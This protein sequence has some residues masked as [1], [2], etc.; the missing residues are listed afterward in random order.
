MARLWRVC[1]RLRKKKTP[2]A[3]RIPP[4]RSLAG[5]ARQCGFPFVVWVRVAWHFVGFAIGNVIAFGTGEKMVDAVLVVIVNALH[6]G[7]LYVVFLGKALEVAWKRRPNLRRPL[8]VHLWERR[9]TP[10]R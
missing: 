8:G 1:S 10:R 3:V 6:V 4:R 9:S 7:A 5:A 2:L